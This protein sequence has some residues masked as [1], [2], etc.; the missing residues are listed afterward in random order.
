MYVAQALTA[1]ACVRSALGQ[2]E[3]EELFD[4]LTRHFDGVTPEQFARDLDEKDWVLRIRRGA[5]LVGFTTLSAYQSTIEGRAIHVLYSGDTITDPEVWGSP[6]LA[7]AWIAMVHQIQG[8]RVQE[9]WYW[10]LLSS[11]YRTYR[12]LPMFWREFWPRYDTDTPV[13]TTRLLETLAR[14]RFGDA[15][16]ATTGIVRFATPQRLR[17]RLAVVPE[18]KQQD[19]HV[20]YFLSRNSGHAEGDELVCL[21]Q[22]GADNLTAAGARMVRGTRP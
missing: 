2:D 15:F 18:G 17:N 3:R 12:F 16:N 13:D 10:L 7:R 21:T 4:L 20:A 19:P 8:D 1:G 11:G 22:I 9:P 6:V 5:T 14:E